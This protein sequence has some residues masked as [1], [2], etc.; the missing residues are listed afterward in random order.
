MTRQ[1]MDTA[2][3]VFLVLGCLWSAYMVVA[4]DWPPFR[5]D[6]YL[7][8][9]PSRSDGPVEDIPELGDEAA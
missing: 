4:A 1:L 6:R 7:R 3:L 8:G 9:T 2:L 5:T